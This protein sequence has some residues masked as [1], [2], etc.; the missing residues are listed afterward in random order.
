MPDALRFALRIN[1]PN[2]LREKCFT[3]PL[4]TGYRRDLKKKE[5]RDELM[6]IPFICVT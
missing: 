1:V 5:I 6:K 3:L 2:N 4:A